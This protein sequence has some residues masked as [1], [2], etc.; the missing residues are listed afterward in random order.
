MAA[1]PVRRLT[2]AALSIAL[3]TLATFVIRIPNPAT[4]G[5][6]NL[7]DGLL[8]TLALVFGWRIGGLA[9]GVGSALADALGGYFI[10]APWTLVIKG[11][12]GILVG[13]IAFW[14]TGGGQDTE[15]GLDDQGGRG[16]SDAGGTSGGRHPR[17]IAAF[18]AVLVGGA[19]MV[20]GYYLAGSVL[21]GGIAALTEIPGNLVQAG[22]AVVVALPLSV[23]LRN[24]LKRSDYGPLA[25]R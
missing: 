24:A 7:G 14:G 4:Q 12:E 10:W 22:V 17:R 21:F 15:G 6:I 3:V 11:I 5:Y 1:V 18:A 9:G 13:T 25:P 20:T 19:W 23:L 16:T 2:L 8:F